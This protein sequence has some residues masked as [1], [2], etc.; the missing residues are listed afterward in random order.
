MV[1]LFKKDAIT[2][3]EEIA[4]LVKEDNALCIASYE[5]N[6]FSTKEKRVGDMKTLWSRFRQGVF[7]RAACLHLSEICCNF[8][9][10]KPPYFPS[11]LLRF[12]IFKWFCCRIIANI[13]QHQRE[14]GVFAEIRPYVLIQLVVIKQ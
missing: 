9:N 12:C 11:V 14:T 8:G 3:P 4:P 6:V 5:E 2:F 1:S 10:V 7:Q 13:S